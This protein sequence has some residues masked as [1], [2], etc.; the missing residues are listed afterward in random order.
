MTAVIDILLATATVL[1]IGM[2]IVVLTGLM[3]WR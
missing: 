1:T 2:T 3:P